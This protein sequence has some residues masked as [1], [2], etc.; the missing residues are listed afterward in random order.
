MSNKTCSTCNLSF[1]ESD[2]LK[3]RFKCKSCRSQQRKQNYAK[4]V[5]D[6][7][8]SEGDK[9][10]SKCNLSRNIKLFKVGT[11]ICIECSCEMR[12]NKRAETSSVKPV[13]S[14]ITCPDGYKV[15]KLCFTVKS[16]DNFR[17]NRL[18]CK[19]CENKERVAYKNGLIQKKPTPNLSSPEDEFSK[20]LKASCRI[21]IRECLPESY[22]QKLSDENRFGYLYE[23]LNCD[24]ELLKK[25]LQFCYK[26]DMTDDNYGSK[27]NLDH[28]IPINHFD[29][30]NNLDIHKKNCFSWFNISPIICKHNFSK[31]THV[32]TEQLENHVESLKTF[33]NNNNIVPDNEYLLLCAT[34]LG[35]GTS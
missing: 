25:W 29:I 22:T 33:C 3:G 18:K 10:C 27:W 23:L 30:Q 15:C 26:D 20:R 16:D 13:Y 14:Q 7:D 21:R 1:P 34:H 35:A 12:R 2:F 24:M 5:E 4:M 6:K 11:N 31:Q 17:I 8:K 32:D 28:V 9:I 19:S